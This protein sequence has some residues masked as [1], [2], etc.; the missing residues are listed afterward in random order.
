MTN[1]DTALV[2]LILV[3]SVIFIIF[4]VAMVII[5]ISLKKSIDKINNILSDAEDFTHGVSVTGK[6]AASTILGL[7]G[8]VKRS[9]EPKKISRR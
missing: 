1:L 4:G 9:S 3:W 8:K 2:F 7:L 6:A 5:M